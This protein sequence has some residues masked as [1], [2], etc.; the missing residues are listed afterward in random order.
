VRRALA[1]AFLA[2]LTCACSSVPRNDGDWYDEVMLDVSEGRNKD[3]LALLDQVVKKKPDNAWAWANRG[4]V[5]L[6]LKRPDEAGM[7]YR[8][9]LQFQP[10]SPY[11]LTCM[12]TA[13]Y[14]WG[15]LLDS[16]DWAD[17]ALAQDPKFA[18]AMAQKAQALKALNRD[19]EADPLFKK[20]FEI[21]ASLK[22]QFE[23]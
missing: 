7:S 4:T 22:E 18:A 17:K 14:R 11:L 12:A 15:R 13:A 1:A 2:A 3:A 10:D 9:A 23:Q 8:R 19:R 5:L 20:A 16:V 6:N 21:D